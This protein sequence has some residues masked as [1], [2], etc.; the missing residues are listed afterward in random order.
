MTANGTHLQASADW[1]NPRCTDCDRIVLVTMRG[2]CLLCQPTGAPAAQ[3]IGPRRRT[4]TS[5]EAGR[6]V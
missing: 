2:Q 1:P 6:T 5:I 3:T 4:L